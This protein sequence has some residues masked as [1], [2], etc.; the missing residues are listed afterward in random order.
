LK[1]KKL[2]FEKFISGVICLKDIISGLAK[3]GQSAI[4]R[5]FIFLPKRKE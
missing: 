4:V 5:I 3:S 1:N 2:L